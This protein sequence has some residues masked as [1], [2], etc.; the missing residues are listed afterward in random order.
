MLH[1]QLILDFL[2][3]TIKKF[4]FTNQD[5][6]VYELKLTEICFTMRWHICASVA[7]L[8]CRNRLKGLLIKT[9]KEK[10]KLHATCQ[11]HNSFFLF[12]TTLEVSLTKEEQLSFAGNCFNVYKVYN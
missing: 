7:R 8:L 10:H 2:T 4:T 9:T 3:K 5:A 11:P 6:A 12:L 1:L